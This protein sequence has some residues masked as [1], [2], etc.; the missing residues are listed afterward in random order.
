MAEPDRKGVTQ[1]APTS[2]PF[3]VQIERG[4]RAVTDPPSLAA[5]A[6]RSRQR[7]V[8][9]ERR[10]RTGLGLRILAVLILLTAVG[11]WLLSQPPQGA[12]ARVNGEYI[13]A[14][15]VDREILINRVFSSLTA[16]AQDRA[17]TRTAV[18]ERIITQRLEA[19]AVMRTGMTVSD[20]DLDA[21]IMHLSSIQNWTPAQLDT[22]LARQ[23]L[24]RA[25]LRASLH[26]ILLV[27][28]Y[29]D[30][31]L[32]TSVGSPNQVYTVQNNWATQ[33]ARDAKVVRYGDPDGAQAPRPGAPAPDF[34][35]L[36]LDGNSVSMSSL[37][38][39]P[40]LLNFWAPWC[41]PCRVEMPILVNTYKQ[42]HATGPADKGLAV[43][44]VAINSSPSTLAAFRKEFGLPFPVFLD[45]DMRVLNL[46]RIGPIPTSILI[47]RQGVVRWVQVG[48]WNDT[49]LRDKLQL[50]Q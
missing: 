34:T 18:M 27:T 3:D 20:A 41:Q 37:R 31:V 25:D 1:E 11:A 39:G 30:E 35:L 24:S 33:V 9:A 45:T 36:D 32:A 6:I 12:L 19:Q 49:L 13:T 47:D 22:A 16:N 44:A 10:Y 15:Q 28:R 17:E 5:E 42:M 38:G 46:Y 26:D 14:A 2:L 21:E 7:S 29:A 4:R 43:L 8:P 48:A 40:V 23:G 50:I